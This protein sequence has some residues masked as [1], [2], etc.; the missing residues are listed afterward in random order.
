MNS[1]QDGLRAHEPIARI[2]DKRTATLVLVSCALE[3]FP[4]LHLELGDIN[5][6]RGVEK[7][8]SLPK[9]EKSCLTH[10]LLDDD[11]KHLTHSLAVLSVWV[12]NV[13][14]VDD[15]FS[16]KIDFQSNFLAHEFRLN[17]IALIELLHRPDVEAR[18]YVLANEHLNP[19]LLSIN[20]LANFKWSELIRAVVSHLVGVIAVKQVDGILVDLRSVLTYLHLKLVC[21]EVQLL[22]LAFF[23]IAKGD[24]GTAAWLL[25]KARKSTATGH[26]AL[27]GVKPL[28]FVS[29]SSL[30]ATKVSFALVASSLSVL[31]ETALLSV[32]VVATFS[33]VLVVATLRS[34]F[35]EAASVAVLLAIS[36]S[37]SSRTIF[38]SLEPI[39]ISILLGEWSA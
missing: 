12:L 2:N 24:D 1:I 21:K 34:I 8:W 33:S 31:V 29:F 26:S 17:Q 13:T 7:P 5:R 3:A 11:V 27:V 35:V 32:L 14:C 19:V 25:G 23:W 16:F 38:S 22:H 39:S 10:S 9:L 37:F 36:L 15:V 30:V 4:D 18:V 6:A 20:N 28:L